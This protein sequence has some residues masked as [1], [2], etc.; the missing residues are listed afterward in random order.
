MFTVKFIKHGGEAYKSFPVI[1]YSVE[2]VT[3]T[4]IEMEL[5][6]GDIQTEEIS[7]KSPWS[8]AYV[9]NQNGRT[10]DTIRMK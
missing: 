10:I 4:R 2:R 9:T 3:E 1:S 6:N 7:P 8:I 5:P